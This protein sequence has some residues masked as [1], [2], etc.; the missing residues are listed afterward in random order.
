MV[1]Y[2]TKQQ[3]NRRK[4]CASRKL[5]QPKWRTSDSKLSNGRVKRIA[6]D[7]RNEAKEQME[8][9]YPGY[10]FVSCTVH[11]SDVV[12]GAYIRCVMRKRGR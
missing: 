7:I 12:D 9:V 4:W 1:R 6:F 2:I 8:K 10:Q 11:Y 5:K 3:K